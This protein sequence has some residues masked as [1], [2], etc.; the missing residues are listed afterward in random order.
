MLGRTKGKGIVA[1]LKQHKLT[2]KASIATPDTAR[3]PSH[4][5]ARENEASHEPSS[6]SLTDV[7]RSSTKR[8]CAVAKSPQIPFISAEATPNEIFFRG[9]MFAIN[10]YM[11]NGDIE[12]QEFVVKSL[13]LTRG[14]AHKDGVSNA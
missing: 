5:R 1:G 10:H 13:G 12:F 14:E 9:V 4:K 7:P 2:Q 8:P 11:E 3:K 6:S